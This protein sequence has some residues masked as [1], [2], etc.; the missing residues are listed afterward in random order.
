M[1]LQ[2]DKCDRIFARKSA[3]ESH[4]NRKTT[5]KKDE[6]E[7]LKVRVAL[8]EEK[9]S[10]IEQIILGLHPKALDIEEKVQTKHTTQEKSAPKHKNTIISAPEIVKPFLKWIGGKTQII[11]DVLR[12]FPIEMD[13]YHEPFLGGGSVL[14]AVL[15][16]KKQGKL[17]IKNKIYASDLN[18]N[19]INLYKN[20][21]SNPNEL[22]TETN[23]LITEY[24]RAKPKLSV[25]VEVN[26][27]PK[28]LEEALSSTESYYYWVRNKFNSIADEHRSAPSTSAMV[29]FM[30]KTNFR[31]MYRE[32]TNK[33]KRAIFNVPYGN[34]KNPTIINTTHDTRDS[35]VCS[36]VHCISTLIKDVVFTTQSFTNSLKIAKKGDF[37]YLDPPYAPETNTSFVAYNQDGFGLE[38]HNTLFKIVSDDFTKKHVKMLMSNADVKLVRD[39]FPDPKFTTKVIVCRRSI[40]SKKPGSTTNEVLITN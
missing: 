33:E 28:T 25:D 37:A 34:Y 21:Q 15:S 23:I 24:S 36:C 1:S 19:I 11:D 20:I 9:L 31:G 4:K 8:L 22:I 16:Y 7:I 17:T 40:N 2:C 5:C 12:L 6:A 13:N 35:V 30:N 18:Q 14:F 26:R 10:K 38:L 27:T 32:S 39:A 3:F 29:I